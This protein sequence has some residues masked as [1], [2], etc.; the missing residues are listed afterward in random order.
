MGH[1]E[2]QRKNEIQK[3]RDREMGSERDLPRERASGGERQRR[4]REE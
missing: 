4:A 3:V 2:T 1:R